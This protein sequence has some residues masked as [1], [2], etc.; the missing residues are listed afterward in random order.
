MFNGHFILLRSTWNI[1]G[2]NGQTT[3]ATTLAST[4][5]ATTLAS[6]PTVPLGEYLAFTFYKFHYILKI[7]LHCKHLF[8]K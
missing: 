4:A 5:T 7:D 6:T 1:E 8:L 3:T 2:E